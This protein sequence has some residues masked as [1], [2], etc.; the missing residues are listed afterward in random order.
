MSHVT[1]YK[2]YSLY[3]SVNTVLDCEKVGGFPS[4]PGKLEPRYRAHRVLSKT[5]DHVPRVDGGDDGGG[6]TEGGGGTPPDPL[7]VVRLSTTTSESESE[8]ESLSV[9]PPASPQLDS[10]LA[11]LPLCVEKPLKRGSPAMHASVAYGTPARASEAEDWRRSL[12]VA[13]AAG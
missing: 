13:T 8:S 11:M 5:L 12:S 10:M 6:G 1:F 9:A 7:L 4:T 3:I 2:H